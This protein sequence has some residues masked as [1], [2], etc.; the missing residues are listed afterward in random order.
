MKQGEGRCSE[1]SGRSYLHHPAVSPLLDGICPQDT[2]TRLE[3]P[4]VAG[5]PT[6]VL[7]DALAHLTNNRAVIL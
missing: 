2:H 1:M 7:L 6:R 5:Q 4:G 3:P